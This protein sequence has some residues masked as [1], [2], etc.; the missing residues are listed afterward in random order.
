MPSTERYLNDLHIHSM[1]FFQES[2]IKL[3]FVCAKCCEALRILRCVSYED[4]KGMPHLPEE[5]AYGPTDCSGVSHGSCSL[6]NTAG[7]LCSMYWVY[8]HQ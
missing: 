1:T 6:E 8:G 3:M 2:L 4:P 7:M 5:T